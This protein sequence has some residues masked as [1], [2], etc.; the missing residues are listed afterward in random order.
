MRIIDISVPVY[1]GMPAWPKLGG[2]RFIA[3][4]RMAAGKEANLT[5]AEM[6]LHAGTHIDA[7]WHFLEEGLTIDQ[8]PLEAMI[9]KAV[10]AHFPDAETITAA[11]LAALSLPEETSRLL[12]R[13]RNSRFWVEGEQEFRTDFTALSE[14]A[15]RWLADRG[16]KLVGTDYLSIQHYGASTTVHKVLL[17]AGIVLV[18][19]L[20]LA[21]VEPGE[22][23]LVCLPLKLVGVDGSPARAVLIPNSE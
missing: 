7:P 14:D 6:D 12:F 9:G 22:Y 1:P 16:M 23:M 19:G 17:G 10:V 15:A 18:E 13:T 20:N 8:L 3:T 21:D 11:D 5:R 2:V 4:S